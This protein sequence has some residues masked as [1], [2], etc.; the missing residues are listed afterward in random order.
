MFFSSS[1]PTLIERIK[2]INLH[3]NANQFLVIF[4][5]S[6]CFFYS[7]LLWRHVIKLYCKTTENC[8]RIE[9]L[10]SYNHSLWNFANLF[11]SKWEETKKKHDENPSPCGDHLDVSS[12]LT[13]LS[14][15]FCTNLHCLMDFFSF[16]FFCRL[17]WI[18]VMPWVSESISFHFKFIFM[19][20]SVFACIFGEK[21]IF[22][23]SEIFCF[24]FLKRAK[25]K[26]A[27]ILDKATTH[28]FMS[29]LAFFF[30]SC[31]NG[32]FVSEKRNNKTSS[33]LC[34]TFFFGLLLCG[35]YCYLI[36]PIHCKLHWITKRILFSRQR[37][38]RASGSN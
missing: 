33:A 6:C 2:V 3:A 35:R 31:G 19:R 32:S 37:V 13:T 34:N 24:G 18:I 28:S 12:H 23:D 17:I 10:R 16:Y 5:S 26:N 20:I 36:T 29:F 14:T 9:S 15:K 22:Y 1:R 7:T 11:D 38:E 8:I 25:E 21:Q 30:C 27:H 4:F